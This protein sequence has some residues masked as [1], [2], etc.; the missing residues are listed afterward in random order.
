MNMNALSVANYFIELAHKE[1]RH[2][3]QL[4]LMKR[5]YIAHG[6]HSTISRC[7]TQ[8]LIKWK[9]GDTVLSYLLSITHSSNTRLPLSRKKPW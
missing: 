5:V 1:G 7:W 6:S 3:T 9:L 2:I 8:G 4:G